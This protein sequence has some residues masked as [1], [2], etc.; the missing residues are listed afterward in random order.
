MLAMVWPA[1]TVSP[2]ATD[3]DFTV[4]DVGKDNDTWLTWCTVPVAVRVCSI[5]C[6]PTVTTE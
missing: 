1:L 5:A 6:E 2:A 4:P 3:T